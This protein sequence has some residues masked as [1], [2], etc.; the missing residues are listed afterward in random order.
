M[1]IHSQCY[2]CFLR[3]VLSVCDVLKADEDKKKDLLKK[4]MAYLAQAPTVCLRRIFQGSFITLS[5]MSSG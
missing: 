5:L 3:Q 2:P 4:V 1:V